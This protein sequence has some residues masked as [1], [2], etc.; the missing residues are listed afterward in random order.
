MSFASPADS[1]LPQ[2][3]IFKR[4][5]WIDE[6]L[7]SAEDLFAGREVLLEMNISPPQ[8]FTCYHAKLK[9]M[10]P[11]IY[12]I[13]DDDVFPHVSSPHHFGWGVLE[14][15]A[16]SG[17]M[18]FAAGYAGGRVIGRVEMNP[19]FCKQLEAHGD[20]FVICGDI[21]DLNVIETVH[22]KIRELGNPPFT[23]LCGFPCQPFSKQGRQQQFEDIRSGTFLSLLKAV[24]LLDA[25]ALL[26]ECVSEVKENQV[27]QQQLALLAH[28]MGWH[29]DQLLLD[30]QHQWPMK[31]HR[32]F[33]LLTFPEWSTK[34]LVPWSED[35]SLRS[36]QDVCP[37]FGDWPDCEI[38]SLQ[39]TEEEYGI[40]MDTKYGMDKRL[41]TLKDSCQ[42]VLHSYASS[43]SACPCGCRDVP[44]AQTTLTKKGLRGFFI[45]DPRRNVPRWMHPKEMAAL[46][47][48]P[49]HWELVLDH[50]ESLCLMGLVAAPMQVLWCFTGLINGVSC[51]LDEVASLRQDL[52]IEKYKNYIKESYVKTVPMVNI[53]QPDF[54]EIQATDGHRITLA[55]CSSAT[56]A[57]FL[58]A[59]QITLAWGETQ[60]LKECD[61]I[62][63]PSDR[64]VSCEPGTLC[65]D[66]KHKRQKTEGPPECI[67]IGLQHGNE[68]FFSS[69]SAGQFLF[70]VFDEHDIQDHHYA[71]DESG[72][73][74]GRDAR[75][76]YSMRLTTLPRSTFPLPAS[77]IL[78][79][80]GPP[81]PGH[82]DYAPCGFAKKTGLSELAI[83]KAIE[84]ILKQFYDDFNFPLSFKPLWVSKEEP[85][86][87][88]LTPRPF[89]G[90][91]IV[92][93]ACDGHW[94]LL[95][96]VEGPV[97]FDWTYFDGLSDA[98]FGVA[99]TLAQSISSQ[100]GLK[101]ASFQ[102]TVIH[103]QSGPSSCGTI[104]ILHLC[105]ALGLE[106]IL[107]HIDSEL[108]HEWLV[109]R[110]RGTRR[111]AGPSIDKWSAIE[112][113][114]V[115]LSKK[116]VP[117]EHA[118]TRATDAIAR[119]G[120]E[121]I[122]TALG[123]K[124]QWAALKKVASKPAKSFKY[125]TSSELD[126]LIEAKAADKFGAHIPHRRQ[127]DKVSSA[128][129]AMAIDPKALQLEKDA[130][131]DADGDV[132]Q[133]IL[134][135]S[136]HTGAAGLAFCSATEAMPFLKQ[137]RSISTAALGLLV[138]EDIP[139]S[140]RGFAKVVTLRYP[141]VYQ[142]TGD[143]VFLNGC[144]FQL[145]DSEIR[146]NQK[147]NIMQNV[148][149][150]QTT[151]L[152]VTVYKDE[153]QANWD[154]FGNAPIKHILY[155]TPAMTLCKGNCGT[156]CQAYHA[157]VDEDHDQV[158]HEVWARRF[159]NAQG[160]KTEA[161]KA[162]SFVAFLRI[163]TDAR[164]NV[165]K[166]FTQGIY[167][168]PRDE[169]TRSAHGDFSV[170]WLPSADLEKACHVWK[171][172]SE[173]LNITRM[174]NRYGIRVQ[175]KHEQSVHESL[176]PEIDFVKVAVKFVYRIQPLPHG[177][178]R[179]QVAKL[180]KE[181]SWTAR[182]LQPARGSHEGSA[183]DIGT[184]TAPPSL[185]LKAFGR[186]LMITQIRD[187][188]EKQV[189]QP[190]VTSR[191][192]QQHIVHNSGNTKGEVDAWTLPEG[193][194]WSKFLSQQPASSHAK[195]DQKHLDKVTTQLK[196]EL[197]KQMHQDLQANRSTSDDERINKLESGLTEL[198]AQ[199]ETFKNWFAESKHKFDQVEGSLTA[200]SN[201]AEIQKQEIGQL[202]SEVA[203]ST[204][205]LTHNL[206]HH[207]GTF[208]TEIGKELESTMTDRFDRLEAMMAKK[209]R[210]QE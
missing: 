141:A 165:L 70:Q 75:L 68:C 55:A 123:A 5:E 160:Q 29:F 89:N 4:L 171:T 82:F 101:V 175:S 96:A 149:V 87:P 210:T 58:A 11:I 129:S 6:G 135:D 186:D 21:G 179:N 71:T 162:D 204:D 208:R 118:K 22:R 110:D 80:H 199:G 88:P 17:A 159:T 127:K 190:F 142:A 133:Q 195:P 191:R 184:D 153:L 63:A 126:A 148:A 2:V 137:N 132:I 158:L 97:G 77:K 8:K 40:F 102:H 122:T 72:R 10:D 94:F 202:R 109:F 206:Q 20:S 107:S 93:V 26:A 52:V 156:G 170:I 47:T 59:E 182:P 120:L 7:F 53:S 108:L 105:S 39:L 189:T 112:E 164:D 41:V 139:V 95:Y 99:W 136:V 115:I 174:R 90:E 44:F 201:N 181:F 198:Q 152:K 34:P 116:G 104:L 50:K 57:Q 31:R 36:I 15:C 128:P 119:I 161:T 194:P 106:G 66:R 124:N 172:T 207:L 193:D 163:I 49:P 9:S 85:R 48:L 33:G 209:S 138:V 35:F 32:W 125:V 177:L 187:R 192:T 27:V 200:L 76:W 145:G 113:L 1:G 134:F 188:S 3:S 83:L 117:T 56:A 24:R 67:Y 146:R 147:V 37:A 167:F 73:I 169:T 23:I 79:Y 114:A 12:L 25:Q 151:V 28:Q 45:M 14:L 185:T 65:I 173:A 62:L 54:I 64:L 100:L 203:S 30:L 51:Q 183:W 18:G 155:V 43:L 150:V 157:P 197:K 196:E 154:S 13:A 131:V 140:E 16:G 86:T 92:P 143:P 111:A 84:S 144:L 42:T 46:L 60:I 205:Q 74:F 180:L 69:L 81:P 103:A 78:T 61:F 19:L 178:Q 130:F 91:I 121:D 98:L 166:S 38:E 176:R 168:E